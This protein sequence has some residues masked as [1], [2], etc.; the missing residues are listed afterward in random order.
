MPNTD[1]VDFD[2][3]GMGDACDPDDDNDGVVDE[4][5]F[6]SATLIPETIPTAQLHN[7]RYALT[8]SPDKTIFESNNKIVITTTYTSGCSCEQIVN[9]ADLGQGH[10]KFGCSK[11]VLEQWHDLVSH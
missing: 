6:C 10:I 1:Q 2:A 5:D 3:D 11:S 8:G 4:A 7:N 9:Q